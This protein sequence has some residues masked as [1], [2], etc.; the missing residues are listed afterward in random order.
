MDF[1][2]VE[3]VHQ[4]Q[5]NQEEGTDMPC[6]VYCHGVPLSGKKYDGTFQKCQKKVY[7][8]IFRQFTVQW[9][10]NQLLKAQQNQEGDTDIPFTVTV[11]LFQE[12]TTM[13]LFI[14]TEF[15]TTYVFSSY[16]SIKK[17]TE[18]HIHDHSCMYVS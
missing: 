11:Y 7:R 3:K 10:K 16:C 18:Q 2:P 14:L 15:L 5:Q 4:A 1:P 8:W 13:S 6:T 12:K 9:T 17:T